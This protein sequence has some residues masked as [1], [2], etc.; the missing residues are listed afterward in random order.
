MA[1]R[2]IMKL[3]EYLESYTV[4]NLKPLAALCEDRLPTRKAELIACVAQQ[5]SSSEGLRRQWQQLDDLSL[6]ALSQAVHSDGGDFDTAA[7][8][9]HYGKLPPRPESRYGWK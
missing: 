3:R 1:G 6:K 8:L 4:E 7:F 9:A 2:G 5:M